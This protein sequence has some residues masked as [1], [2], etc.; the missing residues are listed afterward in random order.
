MGD[1]LIAL[2]KTPVPTILAAGG[3]LFIFLA[4][5]GRFGATIATDKVKQGYAAVIGILLLS[6]GTALYAAPYIIP[7]PTP[8]PTTAPPLSSETPI[9][10]HTP[11]PTTSLPTATLHPSLTPQPTP[12]QP[13]PQPEPLLLD[14][15]PGGDAQQTGICVIGVG[16]CAEFIPWAQAEEEI[17]QRLLPQVPIVPA[18]STLALKDYQGKPNWV[19]Q[20]IDPG[21]NEV[22]HV[23]IGK[24]PLND[25]HFD[26]KVRLGTPS[27][28]AVV[29]ATFQRY[30]DG[31]YRSQ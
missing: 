25:W 9:P 1:I 31:S 6:A 21:G 13:T 23:W 14:W 11:P 28:P 29:W 22:G 24:D 19:V 3:I 18:E 12:V 5:G 16:G 20:I 15:E 30:S 10:T 2:Q 17:R 8:T 4:V 26:G 7:I 27:T